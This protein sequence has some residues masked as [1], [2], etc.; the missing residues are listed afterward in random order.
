M[1][2]VTVM[3]EM[4]SKINIAAKFIAFVLLM[5]MLTAFY[6]SLKKR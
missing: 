2:D 3:A 4:L 1:R 6:K 5:I